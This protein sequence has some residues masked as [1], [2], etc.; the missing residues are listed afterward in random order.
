[1]MVRADGVLSPAE[2]SALSTL[3]RDVGSLRF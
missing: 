3:A 1:M 2:S